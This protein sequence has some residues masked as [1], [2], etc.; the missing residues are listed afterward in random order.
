[1]KTLLDLAK[2]MDALPKKLAE[3][4]SERAKEVARAIHKDLVTVTPV[5]KSEALSNWV[6]T[7]DEPWSVPLPPYYEGEKGSTQSESIAAAL[8]QGEQQ[9]KLKEPGQPIFISNNAPHIRELNDGSSAQAPAGFV[10]RSI[11]YARKVSERVG[12]KIKA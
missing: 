5:D 3:A 4:N 8:Q 9:L 10:E 7:V 12:I 6:L 2:R 11:L 1:M